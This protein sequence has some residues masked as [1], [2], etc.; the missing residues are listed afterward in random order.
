MFGFE[1]VSSGNEAENRRA[2]CEGLLKIFEE[3]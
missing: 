1:D 3:N 2:F